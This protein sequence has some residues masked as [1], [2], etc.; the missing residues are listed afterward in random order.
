[1]VFDSNTRLRLVSFQFFSMVFEIQVDIFASLALCTGCSAR[2]SF[3][4]PDP[5]IWPITTFRLSITAFQHSTQANPTNALP[6]D[7][8]L[9][10]LGNHLGNTF[11]KMGTNLGPIGDQLEN[12]TGPLN[13]D[14]WNN[15]VLLWRLLGNNFGYTVGVLWDCSGTTQDYFGL[16]RGYVGT[17]WGLLS[18]KLGATWGLLVEY[19]WAP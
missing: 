18:D 5:L 12:A 14:S 15:W 19:I 13:D 3:C 8:T 9:A 11:H 2:S 17:T 7:T 6:I 16:L 4:P 1:M 10:T